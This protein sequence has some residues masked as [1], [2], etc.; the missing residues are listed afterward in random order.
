MLRT[1]FFSSR[2]RHTR[3]ALVTEVQTC[4]LPIFFTVTFII[5]LRGEGVRRPPQLRLVEAQD[6]TGVAEHEAVALVL[7]LHELHLLVLDRAGRFLDIRAVLNELFHRLVLDKAH[8]L[9][10]GG[11]RRESNVNV[12]VEAR[13]ADRYV[14]TPLAAETPLRHPGIQ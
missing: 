11:G 6:R 9:P 1:F 13:V 2:R 12:E 5:A 14:T 10:R 7:G 3:C 4:A 8:E